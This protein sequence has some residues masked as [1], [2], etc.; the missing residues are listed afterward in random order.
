[1]IRLE[2][3]G[4]IKLNNHQIGNQKPSMGYCIRWLNPLLLKCGK[5]LCP[6]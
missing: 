3:L 1:M 2:T 6:V 5:Q 4:S